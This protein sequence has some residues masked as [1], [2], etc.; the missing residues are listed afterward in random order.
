MEIK[1]RWD[2][3]VIWTGKAKSLGA[4]VKAALKGNADLRKA[5]LSGAV[6]GGA[7]LRNVDLRNA[8][9]S[10]ANLS[11]AALR[12]ADLSGADL[13]NAVLR[14]ADLRNANLRNAIGVNPFLVC[15]MK[16][17]LDQPGKIRLYK[18]VTQDYESPIYHVT[19]SYKMGETVVVSDADT[20]ENLCGAGVNVADLPWVMHEW[21]KGQR[22]LIVE[23]EAKDIASIPTGTDGKIRLHRCTV[24]GEKSME[25]LGLK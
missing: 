7:D 17:L 22:I 23:F 14:N 4:E 3:K 6:L 10:R 18:L 9:L 5:D 11:Y 19:L 15:P 24:V 21:K 2:A 20:S 1:S 8:N 13:R 16:M 25:E 12:N